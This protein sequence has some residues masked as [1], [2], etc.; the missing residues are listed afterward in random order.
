MVLSQIYRGDEEARWT[1]KLSR[2]T[3]TF[4]TRNIAHESSKTDGA[5]PNIIPAENDT[6]AAVPIFLGLMSATRVARSGI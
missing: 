5:G 2:T 4:G 1:M 6:V 3:S